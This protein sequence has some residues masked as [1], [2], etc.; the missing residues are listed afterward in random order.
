MDLR[1]FLFFAVHIG[2]VGSGKICTAIS[3]L[4][5]GV[6]LSH[7]DNHNISCNEP[8]TNGIGMAKRRLLH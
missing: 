8:M 3:S 7:A 4:H 5:L 1:W 6:A 2:E